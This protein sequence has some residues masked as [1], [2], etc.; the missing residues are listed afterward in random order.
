MMVVVVVVVVSKVLLSLELML[1]LENCSHNIF[2]I[3]NDRYSY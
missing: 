1:V 3:P 2:T